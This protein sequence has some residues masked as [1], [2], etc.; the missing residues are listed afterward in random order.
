M[1]EKKDRGNAG[2]ERAE[3]PKVPVLSI[4]NETV[5]EIQLSP[6]VFAGRVNDHLI[7]EAVRHYRAGGRRG[8][9]MAKIRALVSGSGRK[10]WRQKGTGRA[11]VGETRTPL[12]RHGGTP[13]DPRPYPANARTRSGKKK[14]PGAGGFSVP[15]E[16]AGREWITRSPS[17]AAGSRQWRDGSSAVR[18][19]WRCLRP[20]AI[21]HSPRR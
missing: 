19:E 9:H 15:R 21:R 8:S 13:G 2:A 17:A 18:P 5:R 12:W 6:T 7:Y 14:P 20:G 4:Q 3:S 1:A 16:N 10:P 11:R